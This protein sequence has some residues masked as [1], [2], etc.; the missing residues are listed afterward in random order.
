MP[1][2]ALPETVQP[3]GHGIFAI[4]TGFHRPLFD[5][6]YLV[7]ERG[8]ALFI[9]TG[10]N[11][12]V[13]RLLA[14]LDALG[15]TR[16]HVDHVIPTHVHLDHAGGAGALMAALPAARLV[17]H[18]RGAPHMVDPAKLVAG[19]IAVYGEAEYRRLYG[20]LTPVPAAR[21]VAAADGERFTLGGSAF[22]CLHTPGHAL[23]H[24]CI[25][26]LD[27][28]CAFT[29]DTFGLSYREFDVDGRAFVVPTTSPTQ[30][31]PDQ[32]AASIDRIVALQPPALY[33][34]HYSRVMDIPRLAGL[35]HR[36]LAASVASA[37]RHADRP[38]RTARLTADLREL[39]LGELA[40]HGC[41]LDA[42]AVEAVLGLDLGLNVAGMEAWLDRG[43]RPAGRA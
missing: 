33:L 23:H 2:A 12:G 9:D 37:R 43:A 10:A 32:L 22:A 15:I 29:G 24:Q 14:A 4:D 19:S 39:W 35:L 18:P 3:L 26:D 27:T 25:V 6:A 16:D 36:Q 11:P 13:P 7:V 31:D 41:R 1:D 5:A 28:G 8:R 30:F 21:V 34:T 38:D 40:A 42:A 17:A 20:E